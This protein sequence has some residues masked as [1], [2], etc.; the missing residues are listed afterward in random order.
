M[1]L[2]ILVAAW[3]AIT[4]TTAIILQGVQFYRDRSILLLTAT[5]SF[6]AD[7]GNPK[8]RLVFELEIVNHGRRVAY[9]EDAGIEMPVTSPKPGT[10]NNSAVINIFPR[11]QTRSI[12]LNEGQKTIL[13][14]D[15]FPKEFAR[16]LGK[17]GT[18]FVKD[19]R[20]R[21][22]K[23]TFWVTTHRDD[24]TSK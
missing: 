1:T 7:L 5:H 24:L 2:Q 14:L 16:A 20:G 4:G 9:L 3:G 22:F 19:T 11:N 12:A 8:G 13:T 18:V 23:K 21:A 10:W 6:S 15:P 17:K